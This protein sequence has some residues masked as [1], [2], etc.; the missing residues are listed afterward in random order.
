VRLQALLKLGEFNGQ[1]QTNE[2]FAV[3]DASQAPAR[4]QIPG[5]L[6]ARMEQVNE[7]GADEN[8]PL[9]RSRK[10]AFG[11][12][13][14]EGDRLFDEDMHAAVDRGQALRD[15]EVGGRDDVQHVQ[16]GL[17]EHLLQRSERR[18]DSVLGGK[19]T[20]SA[21]IDVRD[22]DEFRVS[23]GLNV[24]SVVPGHLSTPNDPCPQHRNRL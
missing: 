5:L 18:A 1:I 7:I 20:R 12:H 3:D 22:G 23:L 4:D 11:I 9:R 14:Q 16:V 19:L 2:A 13:R 15:V 17:I 24:L 10:E 6:E 21:L 8:L